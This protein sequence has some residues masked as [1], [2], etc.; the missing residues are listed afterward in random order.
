[1]CTVRELREFIYQHWGIVNILIIT[2]SISYEFDQI[3]ESLVALDEFQVFGFSYN[4]LSNK[5][6]IRAK[7]RV[8]GEV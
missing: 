3:T 1:M 2:P 7:E 5:L 6:T 4:D 8:N